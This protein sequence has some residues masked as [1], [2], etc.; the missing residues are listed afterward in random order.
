M[1]LASYAQACKKV[2]TETKRCAF[3]GKLIVTKPLVDPIQS[4][5]EVESNNVAKETLT[6]KRLL[7]N[8]CSDRLLYI[9]ILLGEED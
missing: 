1:R 7:R 8:P 2:S 5:M 4:S 6:L 9:D 3:R